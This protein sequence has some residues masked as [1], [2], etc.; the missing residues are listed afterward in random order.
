MA[1]R[2]LIVKQTA[3]LSLIPRLLILSLFMILAAL[4]GMEEPALMGAGAYVVVSFVLRKTL[5]RHH[6]RGMVHLKR[7]EFA[8]ALIQFQQS[9]DFFS[10][11]GWVDQWRH[12]VFLSSNRTSYQKMALLNMAY[13]HNRMGEKEIAKELYHRTVARFPQSALARAAVQMA[14]SEGLGNTPDQT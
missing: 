10:R 8:S 11:H 5:A 13:C 3:W 14:N 1:S 12:L 4:A 9:Y 2:Q 7:E 6:Q